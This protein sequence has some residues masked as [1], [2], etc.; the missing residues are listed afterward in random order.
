MKKV[1]FAH[2]MA[3]YGSKREKDV[4]RLIE[5]AFDGWK[6]INPNSRVHQKA[7]EII[8]FRYFPLL[9]SSCDA[10]V[11]IPHKD[12][13]FGSG[14]YQEILAAVDAKIKIYTVKARPGESPRLTSLAYKNV[15]PLSIQETKNHR[16]KVR[17]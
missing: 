8:G 3:S 17:G 12:G 4:L 2:P 5:A 6:V 7:C 10:V 13:M 14:T 15:T 9:V 11:A 16:K 1:Y